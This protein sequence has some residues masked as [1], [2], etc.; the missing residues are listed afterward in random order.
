MKQFFTLFLVCI[1]FS[2]ADEQDAPLGDSDTFVKMYGGPNSDIAF[3]AK[4]TDDGGFIL[5][6][7]TEIESNSGLGSYYKIKLI[8]T[9]QFGNTAWESVY[10]PE[11]TEPVTYSLK[12]RSLI[13]TNDGYI[14]VGDRI[15]H[16]DGFVSVS[17][18]SQMQL[19]KVNISGNQTNEITFTN[20]NP[21]SSSFGFDVLQDV[22]GNIAVL[23]AINSNTSAGDS[24]LIIHYNPSLSANAICSDKYLNN[25]TLDNGLPLIAKS[26]YQNPNDETFVVAGT[27]GTNGSSDFRLTVFNNCGTVA[28]GGKLI[29]NGSEYELGQV[30]AINNGFACVGTTSSTDKTDKDMFIILLDKEGVPTRIVRITNIGEKGTAVGSEGDITNDE[31]GITIAATSDGGFI[32]AGSSISNSRGETDILV[33]KT[34]ALG[35]V[36]WFIRLGDVNP[37]YATHIEQCSDGGYIVFGNTELGGVN[38]MVLTKISKYG[39]LN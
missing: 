16:P 19:L 31:E 21:N 17:S 35:D 3:F 5:L 30:I 23:G 18:L 27:E 37:E 32:V 2:C 9:D 7:T 10:P 33:I 12:G 36:Q 22:G 8:K 6:G 26:F 14:V 24:T 39:E 29:N 1:F 28:S 34:E 15:N 4:E 11:F 20:E 38:T 13:E 25:Y